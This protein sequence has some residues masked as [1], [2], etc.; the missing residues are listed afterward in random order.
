MRSVNLADEDSTTLIQGWGDNVALNTLMGVKYIL[1][2]YDNGMY[3][4]TFMDSA[5][6]I[7]AYE[8]SNFLSMGYAY[9]KYL[10]YD[11]FMSIPIENRG[12]ALLEGCVLT[13]D[14]LK[15]Y[16]M[17][18]DYIPYVHMKDFNE[19]V[20]Q[21]NVN[22]RKNEMLDI[23]EFKEDYIRGTITVSDDKILF[24]SI[25]YDRGWKLWVDGK[26][27]PLYCIDNGLMGTYLL[28]GSHNIEVKW[29]NP[30]NKYIM[31]ITAMGIMLYI[32]YYVYILKKMKEK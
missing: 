22:E 4:Y 21:K 3:G 30:A 6:A 24:F 10:D 13:D 12:M 17:P 19:K 23:K 26:E 8:N 15:Q 25:P 27:H 5:G 29:L 9:D 14:E 18:M 1:S 2:S 7:Q 31:V 11:E 16:A 28:T 32:C 20:Y